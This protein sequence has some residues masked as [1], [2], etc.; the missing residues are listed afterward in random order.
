MGTSCQIA[1]CK[2]DTPAAL[3]EQRLCVLHFTLSLEAGCS[4][5]RRETAL[6]NAPHERQ[7]EIMKFITEHGERLARVATSGLHL[8]D[9]LKAR[10]LSTFLTLMNLRENL[11]RSNMRSSFGRSGHLPR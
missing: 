9:D 5:M 7:R 2:N 6:G 3:A 1:G 11:D 8:T 4:E 10:I